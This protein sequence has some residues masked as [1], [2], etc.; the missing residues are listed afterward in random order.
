MPSH[1]ICH[2]SNQEMAALI[3]FLKKQS[4]VDRGSPPKFIKPLGR[5]LTFWGEFPLFSAENI[6]HNA[7]YADKVKLEANAK[8][9]EY[10]ALSCTGCHGEKLKGAAA[11][12]PEQPPIPDI[13]S[14][15]K[16][17]N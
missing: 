3:S 7:I 13:S 10:L 17:G 6:D 8:Y 9:G 15:G 16:L 11:H 5:V 4:P 1:E 2:I 14:T 12:S